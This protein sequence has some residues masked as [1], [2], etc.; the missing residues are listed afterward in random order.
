MARQ[1]IKQPNGL[2]A[3]FSSIIDNFVS[4]NMT[5]E[6]LLE[7]DVEDYRQ[8]RRLEIEE[9]IESLEKGE[10]YHPFTKSWDEAIRQLREINGDE[11]ADFFD[12]FG[13]RPIDNEGNCDIIN[14]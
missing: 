14:S 8:S 11:R 12:D 2:Y 7:K 3:V 9:V 6:T 10:K 13:R 4:V 1:I 5:P